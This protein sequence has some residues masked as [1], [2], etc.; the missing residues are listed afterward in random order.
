VNGG[1]KI[2]YTSL[3][4]II[5]KWD[6]IGG[7]VGK[8]M[9]RERTVARRNMNRGGK[10]TQKEGI[11]AKANFFISGDFCN[12]REENIRMG[13]K[14]R[15]GYRDGTQMLN[16][17]KGE[18]PLKD[19]LRPRS[20][21]LKGS[22]WGKKRHLGGGGQS[23]NSFQFERGEARNYLSKRDWGG[24]RLKKKNLCAGHKTV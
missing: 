16:S 3:A 2:N 1:E 13:G 5:L 20:R 23:G 8:F 7:G 15:E 24:P 10:R 19:S 22:S 12:H 17:R 4:G 6:S 11:R 9:A 14:V 18:G 21:K